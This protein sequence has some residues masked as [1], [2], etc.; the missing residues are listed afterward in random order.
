M[1]HETK[2]KRVGFRGIDYLDKTAFDA[3]IQAARS[4]GVELD[5]DSWYDSSGKWQ[6]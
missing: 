3:L 2:L 1:L 4:C 5:E 6:S